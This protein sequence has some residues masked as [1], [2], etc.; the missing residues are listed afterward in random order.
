VPQLCP[1]HR[2]TRATIALQ[3]GGGRGSK[4]QPDSRLVQIVVDVFFGVPT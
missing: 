2:Q 4:C 3:A 1:C